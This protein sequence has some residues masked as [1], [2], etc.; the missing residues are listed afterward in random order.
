MV[1]LVD[2]LDSKS[3]IRKDV[4]V[5]FRPGAPLQNLLTHWLV[6][7]ATEQKTVDFIL[8][9]IADAGEVSARKLFGEYALYCNGKVVAL[10]CDDELFVKPTKSGKTYIG[11]IVEAPPYKGAKPSFLISGDIWEDADWLTELIKLTAA[12]LPMPNLKKI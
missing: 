2:A 10:V 1:E 8:E 6:R 11:K 9:Q 7:M 12:E 3:C 5:R 4:S